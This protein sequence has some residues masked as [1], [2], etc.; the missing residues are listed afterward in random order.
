MNFKY[1]FSKERYK[2]ISVTPYIDTSWG[3]K[4]LSVRFSYYDKFWNKYK[5]DF[6]YGSGNISKE[7]IEAILNKRYT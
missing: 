7:D 6:F 3:T 4:A 1:L 5:T 2:V